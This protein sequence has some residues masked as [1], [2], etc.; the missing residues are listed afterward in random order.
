MRGRMTA[1]ML[2]ASMSV[3]MPGSAEPTAQ[4][5]EFS[6]LQ[7]WADDDHNAA[8]DVFLNT[9]MDMRD[10][11]WQSLCALAQSQTN[12]RGFFEL[13]F[14]P[15]LIGGENT[16]LFT[17][18]FEP[19]LDGSRRQTARFRYPLYR[20]PPEVDGLWRTR[21]EIEEFGLL[22][23]RGLEIAWVDDPV[24]VFFL[25]IQGS[26]RVRLAEGGYLRVGYGGRNGHQYRSIGQ[27]MVRRGIYEPHQVSAQVIQSWV[28]RNPIEGQELLRHNPSYVFFREVQIS[29]PNDG[30]LGAMNR[31]ITPHRTI[32]V[33]PDYTPL[34]APVWIEK[35]GETPIRRLMIAQDTGS[36]IQGAQRADIFYGP[37]DQAGREAGRIRD[38]GRMIVLLPI[39]IAHRMVPDA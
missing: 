7:G 24:E 36:A 16:A 23:G 9:C 39:E 6:D 10:S 11:E 5:L 35:G 32:A 13:F 15:V 28:R 21:A 26:G 29:D 17:G 20:L 38:P 31:S 8:L 19:E 33:D 25:Q 22:E 2:A 12:A 37:G 27:E 4:V 30:P 18:Y 3:A 1:L 14:R 34:G